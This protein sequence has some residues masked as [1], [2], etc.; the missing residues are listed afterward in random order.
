[1]SCDIQ[2]SS[3]S[4][5]QDQDG[6]KLVQG[7][8]TAQSTIREASWSLC[9]LGDHIKLALK[10]GGQQELESLGT[11]GE[12]LKSFPFPWVTGVARSHYVP[13]MALSSATAQS[14]Q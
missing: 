13:W 2:P 8:Q 14:H 4:G 9:L 12:D 10:G 6:V 11:E 3:L 7:F 1:M 5:N